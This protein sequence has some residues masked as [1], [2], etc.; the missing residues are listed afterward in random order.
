M[1]TPAQIKDR[2]SHAQARQI[3]YN[4]N[5]T[6]GHGQGSGMWRADCSGLVCAIANLPQGL[7]CPSTSELTAS[8]VGAPINRGSVVPYRTVTMTTAADGTGHPFGHVGL[9]VGYNPGTDQIQIQEHGGGI[10]PDIRWLPAGMAYD[11]VARYGSYRP[12][13]L[14]HLNNVSGPSA[15][16]VVVNKPTP[17]RG[18]KFPLSS[19]YFGDIKGPDESHGG[20]YP[21]EKPYVAAIQRVVGVG[22]DGIYGPVTI[23][24]V[25]AWQ[26]AHKLPATG[27]VDASVWKVMGL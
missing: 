15:P 11:S 17:A 3:Q 23:A 9:V 25:T 26:R 14:Y 13:K 19:G 18:T 6:D 2:S 21:S 8:F 4:Q 1:Y 5:A 22:A 24:A 10:G 16:V 7:G 20:F 27:K 12:F